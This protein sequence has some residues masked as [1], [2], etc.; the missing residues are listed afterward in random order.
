[1]KLVVLVSDSVFNILT[2][3]LDHVSNVTS[4]VTL[5]RVDCDFPTNPALSVF[6]QNE[7]WFDCKVYNAP[8][9]LLG[10]VDGEQKGVI[11]PDG[12]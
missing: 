2:T 9:V 6:S 10:A 5:Q 8:S 7:S 11:Q 12:H 4:Q 3:P 1:M